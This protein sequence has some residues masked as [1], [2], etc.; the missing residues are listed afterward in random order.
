MMRKTHIK[1]LLTALLLCILPFLA[2]EAATT[3]TTNS[4]SAMV[5]KLVARINAAPAL[6]ATFTIDGHSG[7]MTMA[8]QMFT[9]ECNGMRVYFDG[10]T[11]WTH[12]IADREVTIVEPTASELAEVNPLVILGSINKVF[13]ATKVNS[14]TVRLTPKK[15]KKSDIAELLVTFNSAGTWPT[16]INMVATGGTVKIQSLKF[17]T[18]KTKPQRS[19]F[20]YKA[21]KGVTV[22]DLR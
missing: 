13:A 12:S 9:F 10:K 11:Q 5:D 3:K 1:S 15:G 19:A 2:A 20:Q 7:K 18:S 16:A 22:N 14:G 17:T 8:G 21:T 6:S 4:A